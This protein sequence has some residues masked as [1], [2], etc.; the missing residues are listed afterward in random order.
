MNV[1]KWLVFVWAAHKTWKLGRALLR[2][3]RLSKKRVS[4]ALIDRYADL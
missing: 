1:Y 2:A 3:R 4:A